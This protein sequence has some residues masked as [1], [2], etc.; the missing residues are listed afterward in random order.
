MEIRRA[1]PEMFEGIHGV[2]RE[3]GGSLTRDDWRRLVDYRFS[4]QS[5]RGWVSVENDQIVGFLGGIFSRRGD[6]RFC[7]LTSWI[8]KREYR[9]ANLQILVPML[10]L[11]DHTLL[12]Y[13]ASPFTAKLFRERLGFQVLDEHL[14][15]IP[16]VTPRLSPRGWKQ[17]KRPHE[18]ESVLVGEERRIWRDH[19]PYPAR[20]VVLAGPRGRHLY[21]VATAT[22]LKRMKVS[23]L[24]YISDPDL[25]VELVNHVQRALLFGMH[26]VVTTVDSRL[27]AGRRIRG[28]LGWKLAQPRLFRPGNPRPT[29]TIDSL[30]TELVLLNPARWT[31]NH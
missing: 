31:F 13:S 21:V 25:F 22:R 8:T 28:A 10:K 2:L 20:H 5:Y 15:V 16:A 7:S 17:L 6:A 24:H 9:K 26:T 23:H 30:Y 29:G 12:N 3:F 4:D 14:V 18:L 11:E 19:L 1:T 27:L